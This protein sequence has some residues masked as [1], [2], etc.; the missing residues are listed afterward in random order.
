MLVEL[1]RMSSHLL[2]QATNGMDIGAVSMMLYGWREREEHA[3]PARDDHRPADEPQL[4]PARRRRRRP[5]R[6]LAGR[7]CSSVCDIVER[8]VAE[9]DE[10]L[11]REPDLARAHRRRRRH[12]HR[13]GLALGVTG[14]I[15]R[16]TGFA[17][18][19]RKAQPYLAVRRGRLRRHLH[20]ERRR[21]ST[22][23][24]SGSTRSSSRSRSCASAWSGC[25]RGDYRVQD[26]KVT[27]PPRARI[28]ESM[29]ALIHHFKL[30]TEG[31]KVPAGETYVAVE[32]P[33]G[34][35]GCYLVSDGT[36]KPVRMHIR[37]P[38]FYNLQSIDA[39]GARAAW[40]PTRSRSSRASTR[41]WAR[42]TAE[43]RSTPRTS[44][45]ARE[46]VARY[47]HPK[48]AILPLAAPRA[49]PGRLGHAR[50]DGRDRRAHS[51]SRPRDVLGTCSFYTMF[52]RA[53]VRQAASCRC[54]RTSRVS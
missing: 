48:S 12:H 46:I 8:G 4:H 23:T 54:A 24:G 31:F 53:P 7:A 52:K 29:E 36:G 33:R 14:P 1:N 6:R 39:D 35:I 9:Y 17:W 41:S 21:A 19:L 51:A 13:G 37:G 28:D 49:G 26:K 11:T 22:A 38:S 45:R 2:F 42:S 50:G 15:L 3:A 16:S 32:S 43:W 47:P 30:F 25:P 5:A 10:L 40:S 18:D 20:R 34:E 44:T 27:P